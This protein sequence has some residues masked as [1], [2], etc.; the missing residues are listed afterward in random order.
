MVFLKSIKFLV[1]LDSPISPPFKFTD[2]TIS[3]GF[4][5]DYKITG[6]ESD[7]T[8]YVDVKGDWGTKVISSD[9]GMSFTT[10]SPGE[11]SSIGNPIEEARDSISGNFTL[12]E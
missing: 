4:R 2:K 3:G 9:I 8:Y 10:L 7:T 5:G 6:L 11:K 12:Q 1:G